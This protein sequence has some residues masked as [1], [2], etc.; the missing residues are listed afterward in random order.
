MTLS[1]TIIVPTNNYDDRTQEENQGFHHLMPHLRLGRI[2]GEE[3]ARRQREAIPLD[4]DV[5]EE[6]AADKL[7]PAKKKEIA[8][9]TARNEGPNVEEVVTKAKARKK[10]SAK[11]ESA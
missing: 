8:V 11:K 5:A 9:L 7:K 6:M 4:F 2:S 3:F 10:K 1:K